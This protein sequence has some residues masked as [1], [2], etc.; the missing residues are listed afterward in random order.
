MDKATCV[1][2]DPQAHKSRYLT[3]APYFLDFSL[4]QK[5]ENLSAA[6]STSH[7]RLSLLP[8]LW[9]L[10]EAGGRGCSRVSERAMQ[11]TQ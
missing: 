10:T 2:A 8:E 1:Y 6:A 5:E 9:T 3:G 7:G 4:G 11:E